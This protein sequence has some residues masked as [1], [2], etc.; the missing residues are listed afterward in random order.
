M[1]LPEKL[2]GLTASQLLGHTA[3]EKFPLIADDGLFQKFVRIVEE[4]LALEFEYHFRRTDPPHWYR[5]PA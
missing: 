5:M 2:T 4:N 3:L 1:L